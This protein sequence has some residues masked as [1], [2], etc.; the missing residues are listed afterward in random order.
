[1][2]AASA[3]GHLRRGLIGEPLDGPALNALA[4][5]TRVRLAPLRRREADPKDALAEAGAASDVVLGVQAA[6][7]VLAAIVS[8]YALA[9]A[10]L[11]VD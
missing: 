1:M 6:A 2:R 4:A 11:A 8:V 9:A 7:R 3:T 10:L 5:R